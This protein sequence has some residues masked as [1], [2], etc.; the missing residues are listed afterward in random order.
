MQSASRA[1]GGSPVTASQVDTIWYEDFGNGFP[2]GWTLSGA[3]SG[4]CPWVYSTDG[5]WG[6]W[7]G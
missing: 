3:N 1:G 7:N 5:S 6:F 4:D 2:A